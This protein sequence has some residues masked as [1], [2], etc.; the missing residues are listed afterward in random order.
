[1][2]T[3]KQKEEWLASDRDHEE[4]SDC[5]FKYDMPAPCTGHAEGPVACRQKDSLLAELALV[6]RS[7]VNP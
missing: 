4:C 2:K 1:M 6:S 7:T 3:D 5:I